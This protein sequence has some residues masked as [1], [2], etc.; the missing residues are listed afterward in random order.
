MESARDEEFLFV[1]HFS[2]SNDVALT[3]QG[4]K[5]RNKKNRGL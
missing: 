4:T 3:V 5:T 1:P 2:S